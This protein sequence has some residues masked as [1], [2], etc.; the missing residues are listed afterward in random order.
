MEEIKTNKVIIY[1][2]QWCGDCRRTHAFLDENK[3][4]YIWIDI[5]EDLEAQKLVQK[6]NRGNCS[7]P[8]LVFPDGSILMNRVIKNWQKN[9]GYTST[10]LISNFSVLFFATQIRVLPKTNQNQ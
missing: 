5:E 3:I 7:V 2:T 10:N 4:D 6:I 8:T 9:L 1:G